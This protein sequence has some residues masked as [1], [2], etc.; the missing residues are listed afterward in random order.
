MKAFIESLADL[1][2]GIMCGRWFDLSEFDTVEE[3]RDAIKKDVLDKSIIAKKTGEQ[4][5]EIIISDYDDAPEGLGEY[6]DLEALLNLQECINQV[7]KGGY[8]EKAF[9]LW[10]DNV[11][12][13]AALRGTNFEPSSLVDDFTDAYYGEYD[14]GE[15]FTEEF[16][17][18]NGILADAPETLVNYFDYGAYARDL[19]ITD[20]IFIDG[21]VFYRN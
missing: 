21:Y 12:G 5:E 6:E 16:V 8:P 10:L 18:E 20:F 11:W 14:S 2:S 1:N 9:F 3:F 7:N 19:F 17:E 15:A 13:L 4:A